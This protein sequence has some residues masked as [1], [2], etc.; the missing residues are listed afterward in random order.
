M[1]ARNLSSLLI[2]LSEVPNQ[3]DIRDKAKRMHRTNLPPR[4]VKRVRNLVKAGHV[5]IEN[6][7]TR[8]AD[9]SGMKT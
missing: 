9:K 7:C 3:L 4:V 1:L 2:K 6:I 8:T 5:Q